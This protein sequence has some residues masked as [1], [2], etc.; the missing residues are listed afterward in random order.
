MLLLGGDFAS[1]K[2][3]AA[4]LPNLIQ[5]LQNFIAKNGYDGLDIDWEYPASI[6]IS[7]LS[8]P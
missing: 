5:K 8:S 2:T 3:N 7:R 4:A 6:W 1:L